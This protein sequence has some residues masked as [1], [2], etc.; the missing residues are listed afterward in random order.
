M[1]ITWCLP[2][3]GT[4]ATEIQTW[5][6]SSLNILR[7]TA[8]WTPFPLPL[9]DSFVLCYKL[10]VDISFP[11][12]PVLVITHECIYAGVVAWSP[13]LGSVR[14]CWASSS[15]H[16]TALAYIQ[17][18]GSITLGVKTIAIVTFQRL[19]V[20]LPPRKDFPAIGASGLTSDQGWGC[21]L[22]C[23]Q[24]VLAGALLD[25]RF[26]PIHVFIA[27]ML[28]FCCQVRERLEVGEGSTKWWLSWGDGQVGS[29]AIDLNFLWPALPIRF[30]DIKSAQYSI[31]QIAL[32]G[33]SVDRF[34]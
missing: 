8:R 21:M 1:K 19:M 15:S 2:C 23:G 32:M 31:H 9:F 26:Q 24:M 10:S 3:L 5:S 14:S 22:R 30:R 20:R 12:L 16:L 6:R 18:G 17:V 7:L 33:E 34:L 11:L 27:L 13:V 29:F 4:R 25:I 28:T